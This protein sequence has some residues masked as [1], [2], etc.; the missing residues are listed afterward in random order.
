M[1]I[2]ITRILIDTQGRELNIRDLCTHLPGIISISP[3]TLSSDHNALTCKIKYCSLFAPWIENELA[4]SEIQH[5]NRV[6]K[7]LDFLPKETQ[8]LVLTSRFQED[9]QNYVQSLSI[10]KTGK[11]GGKIRI[12]ANSR[13]ARKQKQ[14]QKQTP[15]SSEE[16][17]DSIGAET[18]RVESLMRFFGGDMNK[19]LDSS[20]LNGLQ[21][22]LDQAKEIPVPSE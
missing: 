22:D 11:V 21:H 12:A 19:S 8:G 7:I 16:K 1:F 20:F 4:R 15:I 17:P 18:Y 5:L 3:W 6:D 14:K 9:A 2:E 13:V 10:G